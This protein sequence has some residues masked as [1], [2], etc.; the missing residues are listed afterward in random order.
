MKFTLSLWPH[1]AQSLEAFL[2]Q[3]AGSETCATRLVPQTGRGWQWNTHLGA[4]RSREAEPVEELTLVL[5][6]VRGPDADPPVRAGS[7]P[8]LTSFHPKVPVLQKMSTAL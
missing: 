6:P 8:E 5:Q 4:G 2:L 1:P 7:Q 3:L